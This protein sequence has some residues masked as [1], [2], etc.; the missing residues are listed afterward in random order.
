M[1]LALIVEDAKIIRTTLRWQ[2]EELGFDVLEAVNGEEGLLMSRAHNP[3][4]IIM[5]VELPDQSGIDVTRTIRS[6]YEGQ[7]EPGD[8][9]ILLFTGSPLENSDDYN[10][11][12]GQLEKPVVI[13]KFKDTLVTIGL[14][15]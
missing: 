5:D 8:V 2:L 12:D 3:P 4:L 1:A 13:E 7:A 15:K 11:F 6:T 10:L 14:L 9:K